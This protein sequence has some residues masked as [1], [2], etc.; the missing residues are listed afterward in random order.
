[1]ESETDAHNEQVLTLED[2][3]IE[4]T[5]KHA[6]PEIQAR[7]IINAFNTRVQPGLSTFKPSLLLGDWVNPDSFILGACNQIPELHAYNG[8]QKLRRRFNASFKVNTVA[9][10]IKKQTDTFYGAYGSYVLNV[11]PNRFAL[12]WSGLQPKI[13]GVGPHVIHDA[14]FTFNSE[15]GFV[16]QVNYYIKHGSIH[17]LRVPAGYIAKLWL[18]AKPFLLEY[19]EAPYVFESAIFDIV[20]RDNK[21]LF[22]TATDELITHGSIKRVMPHTGRVA[23]TYNNGNLVIISPEI[24]GPTLITSPTHEV[25]SFLDTN[26]QSYTFP[27]EQEKTERLKNN[28]KISQERLNHYVFLTSDSLEIGMKLLVSYKIV[29][30]HKTLSLLGEKGVLNTV[31]NLASVDMA[32]VV[33]SLS[34]QEFLNPYYNAEKNSQPSCFWDKILASFTSELHNFGIELVRFNIESP[35]Y[36]DK[37]IGKKMSEFATM[38]AEA[39][40]KQGIIERQARVQEAEARRD[41][42]T[43]QIKQNQ[44][45]EAIISASRAQLEAKRLEAEGIEIL[46][47]ANA[48]E[49]ELKGEVFKRYPE[50][51]EFQK[52][53]VM[54]DAIGNGKLIM[55]Y[56]AQPIEHML[57]SSN[58]E[59]PMALFNSKSRG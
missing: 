5:L 11:P 39:N 9:I 35:F 55:S 7:N 29:E 50:L 41:A 19:K 16:D 25:S 26:I 28:N 34:S 48:K 21:N 27:S 57:K 53:K 58:F 45:N 20:R 44:I 15:K 4:S 6:D 52:V 47:A 32:K 23:V 24:N 46:A 43:N 36:V 54:A 3:V 22:F 49:L 37:E 8:S 17:I 59:S 30:P 31:E 51:L 12:A 10:T 14:N 42:N 2:V 56:P 40:A 13:Y 38:T 18:G 1:M 33:N